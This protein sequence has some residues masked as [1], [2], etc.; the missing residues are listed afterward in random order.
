[1]IQVKRLKE[2]ARQTAKAA[3]VITGR[4]GETQR[5]TDKAVSAVGAAPTGPC[6]PQMGHLEPTRG[7]ASRDGL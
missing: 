6:P 1:M 7:A 2:P 4:F 5:V 3:A